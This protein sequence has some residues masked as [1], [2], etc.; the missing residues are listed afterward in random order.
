VKDDIR[1]FGLCGMIVTGS[2][3]VF[4][5]YRSHCS[6][7]RDE[8]RAPRPRPDQAKMLSLMTAV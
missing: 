8:L 1:A 7:M 5:F 2:A 3:S 6:H 4:L